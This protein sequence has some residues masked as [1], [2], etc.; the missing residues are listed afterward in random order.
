MAAVR[1]FHWL[2]RAAAVAEQTSELTGRAV[3]WLTL[4][5]ACA[6]GFL[7]FAQNLLSAPWLSEG[8]TYMHAAV[9][10]LGAA[11]TF[12]HDDHVRVDIFYQRFSAPTRAGVNL[13]GNLLMLLPFCLF[14]FYEGWLYAADS[15]AILEG[16]SHTDG[17]PLMFVFKSLIPAMA[18]MLALQCLAD[19]VRCLEVLVY[20]R[21]EGAQS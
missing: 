21:R 10:M 7:V 19:C 14:I 12:R 18:A 2:L 8:V 11:Y 9:F 13:A 3:A 4:G 6:T 20:R 5:L 17:L 15:W 16:S 1:S